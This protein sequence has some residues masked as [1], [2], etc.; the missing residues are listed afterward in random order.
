MQYNKVTPEIIAQIEKIV[1][2]K[3]HTGADI[4]EEAQIPP[5]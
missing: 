1:P 4:N 5:K 3:V 2:G